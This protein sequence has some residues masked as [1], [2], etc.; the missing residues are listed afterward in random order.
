PGA[1]RLVRRGSVFIVAAYAQPRGKETGA[2]MRIALKYA[3]PG[4]RAA[5][6]RW[7]VR[8]ITGAAEK[9]EQSGPASMSGIA[10]VVVPAGSRVLSVTPCMGNHGRL[11][12]ISAVSDSGQEV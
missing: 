8:S 11:L 7:R 4:E 6:P 5:G 2:A 1:A 12:S 10:K 9:P 3:A